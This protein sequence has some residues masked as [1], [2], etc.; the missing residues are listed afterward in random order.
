MPAVA[1]EPVQLQEGGSTLVLPVMKA[2]TQGFSAD[3]PEIRVSTN[4]GGSG[5]GIS[6]AAGGTIDIG[7]SDA[8]HNAAMPSANLL[9]IPLAV[10]SQVIEYNVPSLSTT[11]LHLNGA[12]L[13]D[14][15]T[16]KVTRWNDAA[17]AALNPGVAL[18]DLMIAPIHE[19]YASGDTFLFTTFLSSTS[20]AWKQTVGVGTNPDW[21]HTAS[22]LSAKGNGP[23]VQ[24]CAQTPGCIAYVGISFVAVAG[25]SGLQ[26]AALQN[27]SGAFVLPTRDSIAEP[28]SHADIS[29]DGEASLVN[30]DGA[31]SYPIVNLEYAVIKLHQTDPEHAQA[32]RAFLSWIIDPDHGNDGSFLINSLFM[33]LP[34]NVR[35]ISKHLIASIQ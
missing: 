31:G 25:G 6:S 33:P 29:T 34:A 1:A 15:Y 27:R 17:I 11:H 19:G 35:E 21:S 3:R 5:V 32:I 18:P 13:A 14:I 10:S 28:A 4:G 16:G 23:V 7:A 24:L 22:T 20:P 2:W 9:S 8:H 12:V 26:Y 30:A